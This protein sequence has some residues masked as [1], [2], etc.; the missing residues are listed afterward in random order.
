MTDREHGEAARPRRRPCGSCP[1]RKAAPSGIWHPDEYAKLPEYDRE[2]AEQPQAVF[3]CHQGEG[4]IC[5]GWLAHRDPGDLLAVRMGVM[6]GNVDPCAF[7]Y[8]TSVPLHASGAEAAAHGI[9]EVE[10][11]SERAAA[12]IDKIVRKRGLRSD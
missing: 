2:T 1:Y 5:S 8:S 3:M 10:S 4:D 12:A 6:A 7:E 11:P 9:R